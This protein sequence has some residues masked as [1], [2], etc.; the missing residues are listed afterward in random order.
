MSHRNLE[1]NDKKVDQDVDENRHDE[2]HARGEVQ[3]LVGGSLMFRPL[4]TILK[5]NFIQI[6]FIL[7]K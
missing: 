2:G 4:V 5:K 7:M 3:L 6:F 1:V